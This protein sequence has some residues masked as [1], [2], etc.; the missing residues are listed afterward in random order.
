M[1]LSLLSPSAVYRQAAK[2]Q[3]AGD[4]TTTADTQ[5][6]MCAASIPAG[7]L[8]ARPFGRKA[9]ETAKKLFADS[10]NNKLDL[11]AM[12]GT[13]VCGDC[14]A[15]WNGDW[16]GRYSKSFACN[17]GVFFLQRNEDVAAFLLKVPEPPFVAIFSTKKQQHMIWRTPVSY[18]K[19]VFFVRIDDEILTIRRERVLAAW[20]ALRHAERVMAETK[21]SGKTRNLKPP[22]ALFARELDS[23]KVGMLRPDVEA[24]LLETDNLATVKTLNSLSIG[25][26]WALNFLRFVD[27][28]APPAWRN[29]LTAAPDSDESADEP[30]D[31]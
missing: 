1:T 29:A 21:P 19:D 26:W 7:T 3:S 28:D 14:I 5:C 15:L 27:P 2:L 13:H 24:L 23:A 25:E 20:E 18:S 31:T 16:M 6:I 9:N 8:A 11:R 4:E 10:F 17:E 30:S 12:S 22:A